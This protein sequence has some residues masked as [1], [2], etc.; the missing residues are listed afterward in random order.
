M[1]L[2]LI[3]A[4]LL[5]AT[6]A[7]AQTPLNDVQ[8]KWG[9]GQQNGFQRKTV[10]EID[11][12]DVLAITVDKQ[13]FLTDAGAQLSNGNQSPSD[14]ETELQVLATFLKAVGAYHT[15][16]VNA[17]AS[18]A[19]QAASSSDANRVLID[20]MATDPQLA[21]ART[22]F[23]AGLQELKKLKTIDPATYAAVEQNF[24]SSS[25]YVAAATTIEN[26]LNQLSTTLQQNATTSGA[27]GMTATIVPPD[28]AAR[29]LHLQNYDQNTV[30]S[31]I[32]VP[33]Y[34]PV[35]DSRTQR[36][37]TAAEQFR[38]VAQSLTQVSAQFQ[39]S[40]KELQA[41]LDTLR[42][43]LKTE[44]L[45]A[46][47]NSLIAQL[48]ASARTDLGPILTDATAARDLVHSLNATTLTV[49]GATDADRLLNIA[50][51]LNTTAQTLIDSAQGL[52]DD[53]TKLANDTET[54]VKTTADAALSK[55][56]ALVKQ[57]ASDFL[58]KQTFFITLANNLMSLSQLLGAD[59]RLALSA[60]RIATTARNLDTNT[61]Y[62]TTLDL[63][64]IPGEVHVRDNIVVQAALYRRDANG[65]L[66][67]VTTDSQAFV[68]Q[69]YN[70][71]PDSVRGGLIFVEPRS[72]IERDINYQPAP[73]LG[74][75]WRTGIHG[76]PTWNAISPSF[77][78]TMAMLDF[79]N[80]NTMELGIA[81]G[82]SVFRDLAWVG[83]GRNLQ[84][85]AN[86]FYVGTNPLLLVKLF[87]NG[88][89]R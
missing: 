7:L 76:H 88:G 2:R 30:S 36:E 89:L 26:R 32:A 8:F 58:A 42:T 84:A 20:T 31:T 4:G 56:E 40:M 57:A 86:Y 50:N 34:I 48:K 80:S 21:Q 45:E 11:R 3:A 35:V 38:D 17:V 25:A 13:K 63:R 62:S 75:Y 82:I 5:L 70:I 72:T 55:A 71:F 1:K 53:L 10:P 77:G 49:T 59:S 22:A 78:V 27:L 15:A 18:A 61:D 51:S 67:Q 46:E 41:S 73:A 60:D 47:L 19:K 54:A 64:T 37:I 52:P 83:Y 24:G 44:V 66:T 81:G 79:S 43:S 68:I 6:S 33:N 16:L 28:A 65:Q 69:R 87:Q 85:K 12:Y 74:Y 29:A 14:V 39:Q 23:R 9:N